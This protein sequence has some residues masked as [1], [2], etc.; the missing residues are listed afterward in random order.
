MV[1][2][3]Y[4][5]D[6][7]TAQS[8]D[9]EE[10]E[11]HI[12]VGGKPSKEIRKRVGDIRFWLEDREKRRTKGEH[13]ETSAFTTSAHHE[14]SAPVR[15]TTTPRPKRNTTTPRRILSHI[16]II[17]PARKHQE[18][19][20]QFVKHQSS[21]A[22][23]EAHSFVPSP[24]MANKRKNTYAAYAARPPRKK[25]PPSTP[26]KSSAPPEEPPL[27]TRRHTR[28]TKQP[29]YSDHTAYLDIE[30]SD[31]EPEQKLVG[32][33]SAE[34]DSYTNS[35]DEQSASST[36]SSHQSLSSG[37]PAS[38]SESVDGPMRKRAKAN[39]GR[40]HK[41]VKSVPESAAKEVEV[42]DS[43]SKQQ[44]KSRPKKTKVNM[45]NLNLGMKKDVNRTL[46][47]LSDI[48][49]IFDHMVG[50]GLQTLQSA[51]KYNLEDVCKHVGSRPLKVATMCSGTESPLLAW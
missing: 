21:P 38:E 26:A 51:H 13:G 28:A 44:S 41:P 31:E 36:M 25:T 22:T 1:R 9:S 32:N 16:E 23:A 18:P 6:V 4:T 48:T 24:I 15:A 2:R 49:S 19:L 30:D 27:A 42:A 45:K 29:N 3:R 8:S 33:S 14:N 39:N 34:E 46:P 43:S 5:Y 7:Q 47:P 37:E 10:M 40:P 12:F 20:N 11:E 50:K 35:E 17:V